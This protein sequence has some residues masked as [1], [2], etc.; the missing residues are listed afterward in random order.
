MDHSKLASMVK[1]L[2]EAG[3]IQG[4]KTNHSLR[5]T[6]A[7]RLYDAKVDEQLICEKNR[8]VC[9]MFIIV[10]DLIGC[11]FGSFLH[12]ILTWPIYYRV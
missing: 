5:A 6:A 12:T 8:F 1:R 11:I 3:G 7:T 9:F 10:R 2:C 4:F